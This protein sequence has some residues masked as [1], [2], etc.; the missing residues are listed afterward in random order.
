MQVRQTSILLTINQLQMNSN[1]IKKA[2]QELNTK[3]IKLLNLIFLSLLDLLEYMHCLFKERFMKVWNLQVLQLLNL[4][5]K[6]YLVSN[7]SAL[8]HYYGNKE[9]L[10]RVATWCFSPDEI[11]AYIMFYQCLNFWNYYLLTWHSF[12]LLVS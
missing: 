9:V 2:F 4:K 5:L 6:Y 10:L 3:V 7:F 1:F 12:E 8:N 11:Q